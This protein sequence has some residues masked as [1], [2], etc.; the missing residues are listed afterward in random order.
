MKF[1]SLRKISPEESGKIRLIL[2]AS[3][4][5]SLLAAKYYPLDM[6]NHFF[7]GLFRADSSC[8]MLNLAGIPCP[9]CGMSRAFSGFIQMDFSK[10]MFYNPS[11]VLFFTFSGIFCFVIFAL[12]FFNYKISLNF[13]RFTLSVFLILLLTVWILNI[14][15]GHH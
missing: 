6:L 1:I 5:L 14:Y 8:I 2:F 11:S 12:S 10:S 13:N 3:I 9:F 7:P 4:A 15:F